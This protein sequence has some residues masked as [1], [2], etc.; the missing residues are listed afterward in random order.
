MLNDVRTKY[1]D[2]VVMCAVPAFMMTAIF[3]PALT[4]GAEANRVRRIDPAGQRVD[5]V[6]RQQFLHRDLGVGARRVLVVALDDLDL[7]GL[8]LVGLEL[9]VLL[10]AAVDLLAELGADAGERRD[11]ADL[12]L[13]RL[14]QRGRHGKRSR[15]HENAFDH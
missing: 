9:E 1:G 12:D 7:V 4:T 13:L 11:Q 2:M 14:G 8:E 5:V 3:L 15:R 6:L 10:D